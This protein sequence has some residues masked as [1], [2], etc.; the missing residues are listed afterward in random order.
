VQASWRAASREKL[1]AELERQEREKEQ[2]RRERDRYRQERDRLRKKIERL[3]DEL[4]DVTVICRVFVGTTASA[5]FTPEVSHG[6][7]LSTRIAARC[8]LDSHP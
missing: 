1:I 3:E 8:Q 7:V 5:R 2:L 6:R 4:D